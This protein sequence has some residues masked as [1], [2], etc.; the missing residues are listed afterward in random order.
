MEKRTHVV[1]VRMTEK[2]HRKFGRAAKRQKLS[3]ATWARELM[4]AASA[5]V[6]K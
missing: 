5:P 1:Q 2:D 4:R 6:R 3:L